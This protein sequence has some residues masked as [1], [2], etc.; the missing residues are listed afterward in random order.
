MAIVPRTADAQEILQETAIAL[1]KQIDRYDPA[2]PF[3]PWACRFA[4]NKAKEHLRDQGR[5]KGFL[6]D[7]IAAALLARRN[8]LAP[9]LDRRV[10]P[11]HECLSELPEKNRAVIRKYYFDQASIEETAEE[12]GRSIDA[13]YKS[14]QRIR[15]ALMRCINGK[16]ASLETLS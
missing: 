10:G 7:E 9:E 5:W 15:S 2:Q 4:A 12:V 14:L 3:T 6:D 8:Q 1:W 13:V 11:L 16:A